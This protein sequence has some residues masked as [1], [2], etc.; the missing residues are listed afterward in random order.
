MESL[1]KLREEGLV[2]HLGFSAMGEATALREV[3]KAGVFAT[4]QVPWNLLEARP[5]RNGFRT[6]IAGPV[7]HNATPA[8]SP[9]TASTEE[10]RVALAEFVA[11]GVA[12]LAIRVLAGGAL[13][14]RPPSD[15]TKK[16]SYFPLSQYVADQAKAAELAAQLPEGF[17]I[18]EAAIRYVV[19]L[20]EVTTAVIGFS[21]PEEVEQV[22]AFAERGPLPEEVLGV[23]REAG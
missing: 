19:G 6:H 10:G 18:R 7:A 17:T 9:E 12:V 22:C 5:A 13:A 20:P 11:A 1:E 2:T 16:T 23:I 3:L 15:H 14:G 4:A 21:T 8:T